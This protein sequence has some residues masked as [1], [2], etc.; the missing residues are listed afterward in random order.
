MSTVN[1]RKLLLISAIILPTMA[2]GAAEQPDTLLNVSSA[3]KI[4]ITSALPKISV[5]VSRLDGSPDNFY[6]ETNLPSAVVKDASSQLTF[7]NVSQVAV[8]EVADSLEI[9]FRDASGELMNYHYPLPDL[10]NRSVKTWT[11]PKGSDFGFSIARKGKTKYD[12][13]SQGISI[14]WVGATGAPSGAALS[15]KRSHEYSW[16]MIAG[17]KISRGY[18]SFAVGLG[19]RFRDIETSPGAY[20]H[21]GDD[22]RIVMMPYLPGSKNHMSRI[23]LFNLQ[24][25]LNYGL[26]F[27]HRRNWSLQAGPILNFNTGA[28]IKTK[29]TVGDRD[30]T[31]KTRDIH[32]VPVTVDLFAAVG[33]QDF[34][35][36]VRYAPMN[37][38][39]SRAG[40]D[41]NTI[42][43]GFMIA[44]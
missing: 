44:F 16:N 26:K 37:V 17:L 19:I 18:N 38:L 14:G 34:G 22:G 24:I 29:Y 25:P 20:F 42:S 12:I 35:L 9:S 5:T 21:K 3:S 8:S 39:R 43:T 41:F 31:V 15:M 33:F 32:P 28:S 4:A 27:G 6:Y 11:G 23:D 40:L 1:F 7:Q 2:A 10:E 36:Y 13:V 30:Y